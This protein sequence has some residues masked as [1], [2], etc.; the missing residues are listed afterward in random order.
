MKRSKMA[1]IIIFVSLLVSAVLVYAYMNNAIKNRDKAKMELDTV[2]NRYYAAVL[3]KSSL[4]DQIAQVEINIK[5][6]QERV[7]ALQTDLI[8]AEDDLK[9][10]KG[11]FPELAESIEYSK[12][13][14][15]FA[16]GNGLTILAIESTA[17]DKADISTKTE[18][19]YGTAF[20]INLRGRVKDILAFTGSV[21]SNA[22]FQSSAIDSIMIDI[23]VPLTP[24]QKDAMET[25]AR[26]EQVVAF[27]N[28]LTPYAKLVYA[29][30][31]ILELLEVPYT[32][33]TVEQMKLKIR[34]IIGNKFGADIANKFDNELTDAIELEMADK[35]FG[36]VARIYG[37]EIGKLF[38]AGTPE[39]APKFG[40]TLGALITAEAA[41][42]PPALVGD[43][44]VDLIQTSLDT[45]LED[46]F[47]G[48]VD[49]T[50]IDKVVAAK[51]SEAEKSS[52][53]I[54]LT[55]YT[56]KGS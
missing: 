13:L 56:Y 35:L 32:N 11:R 4:N 51:I 39:L 25:E 23:P 27:K 6:G 3:Q 46:T 28:S 54:T 14:L 53:T 43:L 2:R 12:Y 9:Q 18:T 19:F 8:R 21:V 55:V 7:I 50:V 30:Q 26:A 20:S 45:M 33:L 37:D 52:C 1:W 5:Q 40:G 34:D 15:D 42:I 16:S 49:K 41:K 47:S 22:G 24:E 31:T 44:V 36:I 17:A 29:E 10:A 48:L 38:V